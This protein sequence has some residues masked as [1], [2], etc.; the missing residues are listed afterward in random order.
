MLEASG[1]LDR[2]GFAVA[3]VQQDDGVLAAASARRDG[4]VHRRPVAALLVVELTV[5]PASAQAAL[6][7]DPAL[8]PAQELP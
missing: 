5:Q 4:G 1:R 2:A 8:A 3:V 7:G 6:G